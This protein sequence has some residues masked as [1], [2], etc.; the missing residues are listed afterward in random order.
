MGNVLPAIIQTPAF[1]GSH[2]TTIPMHQPRPQK[3]VSVAD[4]ESP[5]S[6]PVKAPLQQLEQHHFLKSPRVQYLRRAFSPI[7]SWVDRPSS[8]GHIKVDRSSIQALL[9][10]ARLLFL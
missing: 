9:I 5:A 10:A 6:F 3:T 2:I 7:L 8:E 1:Y 4:I